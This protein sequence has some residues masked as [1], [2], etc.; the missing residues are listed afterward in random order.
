[1]KRILWVVL[2]VAIAY[3]RDAADPDRT[4]HADAGRCRRSTETFSDTLLVLGA[5][6]RTDFSVNGDRRRESEH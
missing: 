1:M 2:G 6:T 3:G 5:R 4:D